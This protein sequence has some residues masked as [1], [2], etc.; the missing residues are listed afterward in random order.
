M[1]HCLTIVFFMTKNSASL[2]VDSAFFNYFKNLKMMYV[3]RNLISDMTYGMSV[4][5][6][7]VH[8]YKL[9]NEVRR[10][11]ALGALCS[12]EAPNI[13]SWSSLYTMA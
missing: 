5:S 8:K 13:I 4:A 7:V 2:Y 12:P 11:I 1:L 10:H 3:N 6:V 9:I